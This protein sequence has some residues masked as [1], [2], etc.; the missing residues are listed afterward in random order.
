MT[1][2]RQDVERIAQLA[3]LHVD[4]AQLPQLADQIAHII[5]Y[6]S[7]LD[8]V[9]TGSQAATWLAKSPPQPLRAD[10]VAPA[11]LRR[12]LK[13]FAPALREDLFVVPRL[14]AMEDE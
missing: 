2:S 7:Q 8:A 11:D 5:E 10:E 14:S 9:D 6:V 3:A 13:S 1:L 4:E 12:D